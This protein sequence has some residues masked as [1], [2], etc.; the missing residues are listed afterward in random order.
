[1]RDRENE[2]TEN[3]MNKLY[4][5]LINIDYVLNGNR[6]KKKVKV[7]LQKLLTL[8]LKKYNYIKK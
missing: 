8:T 7:S 6:Q 2:I 5:S 1:M 3:L 4:N